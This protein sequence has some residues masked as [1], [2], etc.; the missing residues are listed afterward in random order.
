MKYVY[1]IAN[2]KDDL[3]KIG[4]TSKSP[5]RRL[6]ELQTGNP[7]TLFLLEYYETENASKVEAYLH[8][9]FSYKRKSG[10]WFRL[11]DNDIEAF[12]KIC[13]VSDNAI[14]LLKDNT[15]FQDKK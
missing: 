14:K 5:H 1:L 4:F 6:L 8:R 9:H 10:E 12:H 7:N 15:Y 11:D 3:Y 2:E 13:M